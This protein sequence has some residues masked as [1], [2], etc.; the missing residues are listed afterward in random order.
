MA[1]TLSLLLQGV[2]ARYTSAVEWIELPL[3]VTAYFATV[4]RD[5]QYGLLLGTAVGLAQD[6]VSHLP[7]GLYGIALA[8]VGYGAAWLARW[9]ETEH[10]L[11]RGTLVAVFF[12]FEK[13]TTTFI[14]TSLLGQTVEVI[15][16]QWL[17]G[18]L[19]TGVVGWPAFRVLDRFRLE[20]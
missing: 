11:I 10:A 8:C 17:L 15:P 13:G 3:L 4:R 20:S 1:A 16:L 5:R 14:R 9:M 7:L 6:A 18:A 2:L 12:F 19:L